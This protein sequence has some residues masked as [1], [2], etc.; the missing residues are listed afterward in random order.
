M[1]HYKIQAFLNGFFPIKTP[2]KIANCEIDLEKL[3]KQ[4]FVS[5]IASGESADEAQKKGMEQ[6]N[7]VLGIFQVYFPIHL[8]IG[9]IHR[10]QVSGEEPFIT[11]IA[12]IL[13]RTRFLPIPQEMV[14][15]IVK[16]TELFANLPSD[17]KSSR[18]IN[19]AINYF[20]K[21]CFLEREYSSEAFLNYYKATEL[22]SHDFN[23]AFVKEVND[24]LNGT[25][26]KDLTDQEMKELRTQKRLIQFTVKQLGISEPFDIPRIVELRNQFGAHANLKDVI[27]SKEDFRN[28]KF[29]A[30]FIIINYLDYLEKE[31]K[32]KS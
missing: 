7:Q 23:K 20:R 21:A 19:K 3:R 27:V 5:T 30:S 18:R 8:E 12:L 17:Q 4:Y 22:V 11:S 15:K 28:C 13:Q 24:Q 2:L 6:I 14:D 29:L 16:S 31:G 25:V 9:S 32:S 26:L 1:N 10:I